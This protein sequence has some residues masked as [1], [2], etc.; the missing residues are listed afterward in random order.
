MSRP[1][2]CQLTPDLAACGRAVINREAAT[3]L[4]VQEEVVD[5][6]LHVS[7]PPASER[8]ERGPLFVPRLRLAMLQL[9]LVHDHMARHSNVSGDKA[10]D[11]RTVQ[12]GHHLSP[13]LA[14]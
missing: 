10:S 13:S 11:N 14:W 1:I 3:R 5:R 2:F 6:D 4:T 8:F 7:V 12:I 9:G